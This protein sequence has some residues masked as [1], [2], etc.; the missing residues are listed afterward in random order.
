MLR[1]VFVFCLF[2]LFFSSFVFAEPEGFQNPQNSFITGFATVFD[3]F[4][5]FI[6][7]FFGN[8]GQGVEDFTLS[9]DSKNFE[10][11]SS[12]LSLSFVNNLKQEKSERKAELFSFKKTVK[13]LFPW[14]KGV[15]LSLSDSQKVATERVYLY[16][17]LSNSSIAVVL[18][19]VSLEG[20]SPDLKKYF[21]VSIERL[22]VEEL[23]GF[24]GLV[25]KEIQLSNVAVLVVKADFS[26]YPGSLPEKFE[27]HFDLQYLLGSKKRLGFYVV[28]NCSE[29]NTCFEGS[30]C[31]DNV[32]NKEHYLCHSDDQLDFYHCNLFSSNCRQVEEKIKYSDLQSCVREADSLNGTYLFFSDSKSFDDSQLSSCSK[33]IVKYVKGGTFYKKELQSLNVKASK[34]SKYNFTCSFMENPSL[35]AIDEIY[36]QMYSGSYFLC[37]P[38]STSSHY[39]C[40]QNFN[41]CLFDSEKNLVSRAKPFQTMEECQERADFLTKKLA[42][43]KN[44]KTFFCYDDSKKS[45]FCS[46]TRSECE[47]DSRTLITWFLKDSG[48]G[49]RGDLE[50]FSQ[51]DKLNSVSLY[52]YKNAYACYTNIFGRYYHTE[53]LERLG[54]ASSLYFGMDS[55]IFSAANSEFSFFPG[56]SKSEQLVSSFLNSF[57]TQNFN[58]FDSCNI[59]SDKMNNDLVLLCDPYFN[60]SFSCTSNLADC[61][62]ESLI[63]NHVLRQLH[64]NAVNSAESSKT[65]DNLL[66]QVPP[67]LDLFSGISELSFRGS[68]ALSQCQNKLKEIQANAYYLCFTGN[69]SEINC[70]NNLTEC[71][72]GPIMTYHNVA[73][74]NDPVNEMRETNIHECLTDLYSSYFIVL[75]EG[76][77]IDGSKMYSCNYSSTVRGETLLSKPRF[78]EK[79]SDCFDE[80]KNLNAPLKEKYILLKSESDFTFNYC[81]SF[82]SFSI[83]EYKPMSALGVF[84]SRENCDSEA[85]KRNESEN[86]GV[87]FYY[88]CKKSFIEKNQLFCADDKADCFGLANDVF[89]SEKKCLDSAAKL[90]LQLNDYWK[91]VSVGSNLYCSMNPSM[92]TVL[93]YYSTFKDCFFS[94]VNSLTV[95]NPRTFFVPLD[96]SGSKQE[97][98]YYAELQK[99][100][101]E[102][103]STFKQDMQFIVLSDLAGNITT[104]KNK[105]LKDL[106]RTIELVLANSGIKLNPVTDRVVGITDKE[107]LGDSKVLGYGS[108]ETV[109]AVISK[110]ES[111]D[112]TAHEIGH[113][114][115]LCDEYLYEYWNRQ[116]KSWTCPNPYPTCCDDSPD[117]DGSGT[118]CFPSKTAKSK[119]GLCVGA[120]MDSSRLCSGSA[121]KYCRSI[122]GP[123]YGPTTMSDFENS[124]TKRYPIDLDIIKNNS[125]LVWYADAFLFTKF[126]EHFYNFYYKQKLAEK[127]EDDGVVIIN[128]TD[129]KGLNDFSG[130]EGLLQGL[131]SEV[132]SKTIWNEKFNIIERFIFQYLN[133]EN[134]L[135]PL[136]KEPALNKIFFV[137]FLND[138][139]YA[140]NES[141]LDLEQK[142]KTEFSGFTGGKVVLNNSAFDDSIP[143]ITTT[144][145]SIDSQDF[146]GKKIFFIFSYNKHLFLSESE[147]SLSDDEMQKLVELRLESF[148]KMLKSKNLY[149]DFVYID[150]H[151]EIE[152]NKEIKFVIEK[153]R[154]LLEEKIVIEETP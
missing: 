24:S 135:V 15:Y 13:E 105:S 56:G 53:A 112:V 103:I 94:Y 3:G 59:A 2:F 42:Q 102:K 98:E 122:M 138:S 7:S 18:S 44:T 50:C 115:K 36:S 66:K 131:L 99:T 97:F 47:N 78:F 54:S 93:N 111:I 65:I 113:T 123:G 107:L 143:I 86:P 61:K 29:S 142:N 1:K 67:V 133:K 119:N 85:S 126:A 110:Y 141:T 20:V 153:M 88:L 17:E 55:F 79:A 21:T 39:F 58:D 132:K 100:Y 26:D 76:D 151:A 104:G 38:S 120:V 22:S 63:K 92:G 137:S 89:D 109:F 16:Q 40:S 4:F 140:S 75:T 70:T 27:A 154:E 125:L 80:I 71:D 84:D 45:Y 62:N 9:L 46:E 43:V 25:S 5:D 14:P 73:R 152:K 48:D 23:T 82:Q 32:C 129:S 124:V 72:G 52:F 121:E 19:S 139:D 12:D 77:L 8:V 37:N 87:E 6:N 127:L 74:L 90:S 10:K 106:E 91:L 117:N 114:F 148:V 64:L 95:E 33:S 116:N 51:A 28:N 96:W 30:L 150:T 35:E 68:N 34:D 60:G 134:F 118:N 41:D 136:L 69:K 57:A 31:K 108:T 146:E 101:F 83:R 81:M 49:Y 130:S 128:F 147:L 145:E 11:F 149:P 144:L